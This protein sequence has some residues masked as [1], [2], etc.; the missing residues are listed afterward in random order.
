MKL[1]FDQLSFEAAHYIPGHKGACAGIHGHT[2]IIKNLTLNVSDLALNEQGIVLDFGDVKEYFKTAWDHKFLIPEIDSE[3]WR[4]IYEECGSVP[5]KDNRKVLRGVSDEVM[6]IIIHNDL[7]KLSHVMEVHFT[8]YEG[9]NQGV[10][11]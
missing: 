3:Y 6:A 1:V 4:H 5:V 9:L 11:V 2:Y 8:L 10:S 7:R